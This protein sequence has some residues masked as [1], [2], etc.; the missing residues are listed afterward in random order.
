MAQVG[1]GENGVMDD[2]VRRY[3]D[4]IESEHRPVFDRL[5]RLIVDACPD[6][7]A[8]CP[9]GCRPTESGGAVSPSRGRSTG[10]RCTY[11]PVVTLASPRG[12]PSWPLDRCLQAEPEDAPS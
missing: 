7:D 4:E 1:L 5:D 6:V 12:T 3:R 10:S 8:C 2:A 9:T 11:R